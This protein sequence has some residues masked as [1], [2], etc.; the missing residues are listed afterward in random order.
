VPGSALNGTG[1]SYQPL[2]VCTVKCLASTGI[3]E[4]FSIRPDL[5]S[6][7]VESG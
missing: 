3:D 7:S 6:I 4:S 1:R 5:N 2:F